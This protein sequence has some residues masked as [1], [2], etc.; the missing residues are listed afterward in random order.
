MALPNF[1]LVMSGY[2]YFQFNISFILNQ[3]NANDAN[4]PKFFIATFEPQELYFIGNENEF[5]SSTGNENGYRVNWDLF[6][7]LFSIFVFFAIILSLAVGIMICRKHKNEKNKHE[8]IA[9][10]EDDNIVSPQTMG[11]AVGN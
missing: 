6:A 3:S 4:V 7:I 5:P 1:S 8:M 10:K 2:Y 9:K 11:V